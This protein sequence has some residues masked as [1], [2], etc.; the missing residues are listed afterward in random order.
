[1]IRLTELAHERW[2]AVLRPGDTAVDATVGNGHD[3]LALARLVGPT[4]RVVGFDIQPDALFAARQRLD[5]ADFL[6]A[7]LFFDDHRKIAEFV[8]GPVRVVCFNLGYLPGGDK[9]ITTRKDSTIDAL[10][11]ASKMLLPGGLLTV[12][13]YRGHPGGAEETDAVRGYL[14]TLPGFEVEEI[15]G[16]DSP[17]S[18]VLFVATKLR[19]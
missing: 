19:S 6:D 10:N 18:P 3:T 8:P 17:V 2:R 4:G 16:S 11:R 15:P 13:G 12:V 1:M 7:R 14:K 9:T 5:D